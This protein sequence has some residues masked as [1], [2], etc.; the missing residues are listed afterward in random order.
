M[1]SALEAERPN[2][3]EMLIEICTLLKENNTLLRGID[4]KLR[5]INLNTS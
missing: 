1:R 3:S 5:K 2:T 4:E